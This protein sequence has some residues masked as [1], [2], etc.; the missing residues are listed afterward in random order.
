MTPVVFPTSR[1][2][3]SRAL[4]RPLFGRLAPVLVFILSS[5]ILLAQDRLKTMPGYE[6]YQKLNREMSNAVKLGALSVV[7]TNDGKAFDYSRDGKR[8]RYDIAARK[9]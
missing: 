1:E 7:W 5:A 9:A 8:Y 2:I 3:P 6:R 4:I